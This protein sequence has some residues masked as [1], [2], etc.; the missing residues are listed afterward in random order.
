MLKP[1][2][3]SWAEVTGSYPEGFLSGEVQAALSRIAARADELDASAMTNDWL[4]LIDRL[5]KPKS[6]HSHEHRADGRQRQ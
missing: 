6:G 4:R 1:H 2:P 5:V 3:A